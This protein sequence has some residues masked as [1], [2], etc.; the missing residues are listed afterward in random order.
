MSQGRL[1]GLLNI[2]SKD[3]PRDFGNDQLELVAIY[4]NQVAI[5]V[6][7]AKLY[8]V[9]RQR[10]AHL[11]ALHEA[12][13]AIAAG[14]T[15]DRRQVLDQI[16][17]QAV[18]RI[19]DVRGPRPVSG[20]L[21]LYD[22]TANELRFESVYPAA[23]WD[24]LK[25]NVGEVRTLDRARAPGGRIGITGRAVIEKMSVRVSDVRVD[26]DYVKINPNTRAELAV[27]LFGGDDVIGVLSLESEASGAFDENDER[28]LVGLAELAVIAIKNS[29]QAE[30]LSRANAVAVLAAWGADTTHDVN[31]E[32]G[33]IRRTVFLLQQRP[34]LPGDIKEWIT[35]IDRCASNLASYALP[36]QPL[37]PGGALEMPHT[38]MLDRVVEVEVES[39]QKIYPKVGWAC[40]LGCPGVKVAMHEQWL[41]RVL[42]HLMRNALNALPAEGTGTVTVRTVMQGRGAC[43]QVEDAGRGIRPEIRTLLFRRPILHEGRRP[44]RGLLLA[45]FLV[46]QHGGRLGL[47]WSEVGKGSR[48][49]FAVPIT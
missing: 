39:F 7:N 32:V 37:E 19:S 22:R 23:L 48:F 30:H 41:R 18:T 13:K 6:Q 31:S 8:E 47:D 14:F 26:P 27:P 17:E 25:N 12:S 29:D 38:A 10:H 40:E 44:G 49:T 2:Y 16:V 5:A 34:R 45:N 24:V 11:E 4:A 15:P 28:A 46:E 43:V 21:Q 3:T 42:R 20:I 33:N 9:A 36:E 35:E 1:I